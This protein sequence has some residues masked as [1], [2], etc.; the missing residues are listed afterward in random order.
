VNTLELRDRLA[1]R[2]RREGLASVAYQTVDSPLGPLWVAVGPR[3]VVAI[4]YGAEPSEAEIERVLRVYGPGII[5]DRRGAAQAARELD[6]YFH[7]RRRTFDVQPDLA[8]L[9]EF[10]SRV[11]HATA[12]VGYGQVTTYREVARRAGNE[13]A[14]RAAGGALR[15]NPVPIIVPCHRVLATGGTL[16][17]YG[18]GIRAKEFLL[19]LEGRDSTVT[20]RARRTVP[21]RAR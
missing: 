12:R 10:T 3:G 11:L 21:D 15:S 5:P 19:S 13:R 18:G 2:A 20:D 17:G 1:S 8:G 7:G 6:E 14:A 16:G 4:H 9:G